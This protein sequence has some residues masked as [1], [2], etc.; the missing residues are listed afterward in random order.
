LVDFFSCF[1]SLAAYARKGVPATSWIRFPVSLRRHRG[2]DV[3]AGSVPCSPPSRRFSSGRSHAAQPA[4]RVVTARAQ[5]KAD[6][7]RAHRVACEAEP[8]LS[9]LL[10]QWLADAREAVTAS[11]PSKAAAM[12]ALGTAL[13]DHRRQGR[14]AGGRDAVMIAA[15]GAAQ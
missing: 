11:R 1:S 14:L 10:N 3:L 13:F 15:A 6:C 8:G 4:A 2:L 9:A 7:L 12:V 5:A